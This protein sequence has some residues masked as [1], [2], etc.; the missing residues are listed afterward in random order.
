MRPEDF[1]YALERAFSL[2]P[3]A[4]SEYPAL[5]GAR[6]CFEQPTTCDLSSEIEV[7]PD[8]ITFHLAFPDPD[9]PYRLALPFA[10]PVP[11]GT[12][13]EDQ[14]FDPVPATGPY[15]IS[16]A[17]KEG[18]VL[19]RNK[20]FRQWSAAAQ[21]DGFVDRMEWTFG[22]DPETTFDRLLA[23]RVDWQA[24][25]ELSTSHPG[26][27]AQAA[28][29]V[30]FYMGINLDAAPFDDVRVRRAVNFAVD[31]AHVQELLGGEGEAPRHVPDPAAQLPRL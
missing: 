29:P 1:R 22:K 19:E 2:N 24:D 11:V 20:E 23:G 21:P 17:G 16:S 28:L 27:L 25:A 7:D 26:Q 12:P 15:V 9:L 10:F 5:A 30:T 8:A 4:V 13:I 18:V 31:R 3:A 6:G 14:R